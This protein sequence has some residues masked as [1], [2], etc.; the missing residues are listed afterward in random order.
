[1]DCLTDSRRPAY[2]QSIA[3]RKSDTRNKGDTMKVLLRVFVST[4]LAL[5]AA[6]AGAQYP[7]KPIV[8]ISPFAPGGT[9][10]FVGRVV[11]Q[12]IMEN[13]PS[14]KMVIETKPGADGQIGS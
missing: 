4:M 1:M 12:K 14:W 9:S 13:N 2:S 8:I 5:A 6:T 10:D 3:I 7:T 11:A